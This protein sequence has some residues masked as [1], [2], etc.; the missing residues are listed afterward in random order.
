MISLITDSLFRKPWSKSSRTGVSTIGSLTTGLWP[1]RNWATQ[2]EVSGKQV[3][4]AP[5]VL[6]A[7]SHHSNY[8]LSSDASCKISWGNRFSR[9]MNPNVNCTCEGSRLHTP[10]E[11][12]PNT[13]TPHSP[14]SWKKCLPWN[15]SLVPKML[16]T[17]DP[18]CSQSVTILFWK[19]CFVPT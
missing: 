17:A 13:I 4:E 18:E 19:V 1:V 2:Q 15:Q 5:S 7:A 16:G 12:H 6:T 9:S 3:R 14:S 11:N 8:C 10:C